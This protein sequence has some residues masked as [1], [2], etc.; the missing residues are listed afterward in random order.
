VALPDILRAFPAGDD[1]EPD[2]RDIG[3]HCGSSS[4]PFAME[5]AQGNPFA[6]TIA[7]VLKS[8]NIPNQTQHECAVPRHP[9]ASLS[10]HQKSPAI[11]APG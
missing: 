9:H 6:A 3:V 1:A 7:I 2:S 10:T 5:I 11:L 4:S 8:Y